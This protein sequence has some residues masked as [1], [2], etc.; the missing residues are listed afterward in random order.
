[1]EGSD[2]KM[3]WVIF[4]PRPSVPGDAQQQAARIGPLSDLLVH[5]VDPVILS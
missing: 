4:A 1:M 3:S 2:E 5:P